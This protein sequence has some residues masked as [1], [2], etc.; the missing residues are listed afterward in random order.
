MFFSTSKR[1]IKYRL[2]R[3]AW[4]VLLILSFFYASCAQAPRREP[5]TPPAQAAT[6]EKPAAEDKQPDKKPALKDLKGYLLP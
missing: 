5:P 4:L 1:P 3:S 2:R 6:S